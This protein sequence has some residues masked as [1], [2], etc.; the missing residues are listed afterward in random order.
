[1]RVKEKQYQYAHVVCV[2]SPPKAEQAESLF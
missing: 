2:E 1:M